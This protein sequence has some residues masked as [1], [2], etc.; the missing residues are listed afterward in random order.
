MYKRRTFAVL[1]GALVLACSVTLGYAVLAWLNDPLHVF[2]GAC[3]DGV[4]RP[5]QRDE[6]VSLDENMRIQAA[7]IIN[8]FAFDSLILGSSVFENSSARE[9][10]RCL[11]GAFANLSIAGSSPYERDIILRYALRTKDIKQ[12]LYTLEAVRLDLPLVFSAYALDNWGFLYNGDSWDDLRIYLSRGYL[13]YNVLDVLC[14]SPHPRLRTLDMPNE[15]GSDPA[16]QERFG[17]LESWFRVFDPRWNSAGFL[18]EAREAHAR[19]RQ[20]V[21]AGAAAPPELVGQLHAYLDAHILTTVREHPQ[22]RFHLV[23]PPYYRAKYAFWLYDEAHTW[24]LHVATVRYL[25]AHTRE[26]PNLLIYAFDDCDF[27][28]DIANFRDMLHFH[29]RFNSYITRSVAAGRHRLTPENVEAHL[30]RTEAR[31]RA[32]DLAGFLGQVEGLAP[33]LNGSRR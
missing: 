30:A 33:G 31:A 25:V 8:N 5:W 24:A 9:A 10:E 3:V 6:L 15:W 21:E 17:G 23:L 7:G 28:D 11:G 18:A 14:N 2:R 16:L 20:G 1:L 32:F 13:K 29:P 26:C 27:V 22:T 19:M 4:C 12:V